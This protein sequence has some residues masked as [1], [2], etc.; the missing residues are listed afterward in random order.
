MQLQY[1]YSA[2]QNN[3]QITQSVDSLSGETVDYAYDSL[4]R[5]ISAATTGPQW[6]LSFGY[7][8][9]G[10]RL[11]QTVTKGSAPS[12]S[13]S[14]NASTNRISSSGYGY[15][16]NGNLTTM[17]YG[18]GSM[19]LTYDVENR[20]TQAV[21]SNGTEQYGYSPDNRRV[22]RKLPSGAEGSQLIYFY[23]ANGDRLATYN[24]FGNGI[25][26]IVK[27][28]RYFAGRRLAVMDR[29]G[30][31]RGNKYLPFGEEQPATANDTDKFATYFRDSS[32]GLDYALN[33][34]Y[35]ST[36]GRFLTP[37]PY[38]SSTRIQDPQ[39]WNQYLYVQNDPTNYIDRSGLDRCPLNSATCID[40]TA[41]GPDPL[42]L[43]LWGHWLTPTIGHGVATSWD[44][45]NI[46]TPSTPPRPQVDWE[47]LPTEGC[48]A[49]EM[50]TFD[51]DD[52]SFSWGA[53]FAGRIAGRA[54]AVGW[55]TARI[56]GESGERVVR[57]ITNLTKNTESIKNTLSGIERVPDLWNRATATIYEVKT[58]SYV[59]FT[60]Q[61]KDMAAW[62]AQNGHRFE[63][64]IRQGGTPSGPLLEAERNGLLTI[65]YFPWP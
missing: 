1:N 2:T 12:N 48:T 28:D 24:Y 27:T 13:V 6:G 44:R 25:F 38:R 30:S 7:D 50:I 39:G 42:D 53:G 63:L 58:M 22:Y 14:V 45:D 52:P 20:V 9:F 26:Q 41:P 64:W 18:A 31:V 33:R 59:S 4:N 54:A 35:S 43:F 46:A 55:V 3:G 65:K 23:G 49:S 56:I 16:L 37:D 36:M 5:L 61:I 19:T 51:C 11:S 34:Y 57:G 8:G 17:P 32:T 60:S 47:Q 10:N 21:N 29:L 40:V 15:D 62:A